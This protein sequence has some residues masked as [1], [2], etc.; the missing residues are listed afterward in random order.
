MERLNELVMQHKFV[1]SRVRTNLA[2][3]P[4]DLTHYKSSKFLRHAILSNA[5]REGPMLALVREMLPDAGITELCLNKCDPARP[6]AAHRDGK[7]SSDLSY[8][9]LFGYFTGGALC[10]EDGRRFE[11]PGTW[12]DFDGRNLTH[13]V[14]PFE[15]E[16]Y[17][18]VA[19]A[20]KHPARVPKRPVPA[21]TQSRPC[22]L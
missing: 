6:M 7:N 12:F 3:G 4:E 10:L 11:K 5:V 9:A 2:T 19:Y 20:R 18:V 16:R 22:D 15:G 14:E 8:I 17:S 21:A 1:P 13:W